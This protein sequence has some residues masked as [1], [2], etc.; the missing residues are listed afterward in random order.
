MID[1][2]HDFSQA[3]TIMLLGMVLVFCFLSALIGA[4]KISAHFLSPCAKDI[5]T[6]CQPA[7][8]NSASSLDPTLMAAIS[9]AIHHHRQTARSE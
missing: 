3:L 6:E 4:I 2:A 9:T 8:E 7:M 5:D 1:I